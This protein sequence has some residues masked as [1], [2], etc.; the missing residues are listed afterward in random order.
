MCTVLVKY[1]FPD[2][3]NRGEI[4]KLFKQIAEARFLGLEGLYSKQ[5]CYDVETREGL[6]V[7]HWESKEQA[8]AFFSLE[9]LER[10]RNT[11]RTEPHCE[12]YDTILAVDNRAGD[13]VFHND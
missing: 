1:K 5:F 3:H 7:Y 4:E 11:Y 9:F 2:H 10:F 8:E 12:Y 6:S 13:I